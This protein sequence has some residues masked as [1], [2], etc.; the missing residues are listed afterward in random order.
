M[1]RDTEENVPPEVSTTGLLADCVCNFT[2][3]GLTAT[4]R[5]ATRGLRKAQMLGSCIGHQEMPLRDLYLVA[6]A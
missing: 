3:D 5:R 2:H 4:A 6:G 1:A